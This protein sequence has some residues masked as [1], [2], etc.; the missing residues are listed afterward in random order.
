MAGRFRRIDA[1]GNSVWLEATYNPIKD[2]H[3]RLYKVAKFANVVTEQVE[4]ADLVRR[5]AELALA[6]ATADQAG[7][8]AEWRV[9]EA[10]VEQAQA[11]LARIEGE[12]ARI[13]RAAGCAT[14]I[15]LG[16]RPQPLQAIEDGAPATVIEASLSAAAAYKGWI[17]GSLSPQG[18]LV[19]D[20]GA[21]GRNFY[22]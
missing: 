22:E 10:A 19:V 17:A 4:K 3:G 5:A 8:E 20:A 7:V 1:R 13:A 18:A 11:R 12:A 14:I 15:T 21:A 9:A 2:Q 6:K 16:R